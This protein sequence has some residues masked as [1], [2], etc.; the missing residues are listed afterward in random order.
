M[1]ALPSQRTSSERTISE[2]ATSERNA[3]ERNASERNAS[4]RTSMTSE[5][6]EIGELIRAKLKQKLNRRARHIKCH[7]ASGHVTL[8][9]IVRCF[10]EMQLAQESALRTRGV[11]SVVNL[12]DVEG[13]EGRD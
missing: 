9:G 8:Y 7:V 11:Q 13:E 6:R 10:Y 12:I 2:R 3:S 5:D 4:E 1:E